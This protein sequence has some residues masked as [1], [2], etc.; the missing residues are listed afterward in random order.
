MHPQR[1]GTPDPERASNLRHPVGVGVKNAAGRAGQPP[2]VLL[3]LRASRKDQN[4][5]DKHARSSP[6]RG[7][8]QMTFIP[9]V[10]VSDNAT[11]PLRSHLRFAQRR[12]LLVEAFQHRAGGIPK[13][14]SIPPTKAVARRYGIPNLTPTRTFR[15]VGPASLGRKSERDTLYRQH[16][17]RLCHP[18]QVKG[19]TPTTI[20]PS[21]HLFTVVTFPSHALEGA[22]DHLRRRALP[23]AVSLGGG[24][25]GVKKSTASAFFTRRIQLVSA[26]PSNLVR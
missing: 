8:T 24:R 16:P 26:T 15:R 5:R 21:S 14:P 1:Y 7:R 13:R 18:I 11:V 19:S 2:R 3:D 10:L 25:P 22:G 4:L 20:L 6:A 17:V 9:P 23:P 12:L